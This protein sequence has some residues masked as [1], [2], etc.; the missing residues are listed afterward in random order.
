[1]PQENIPSLLIEGFSFAFDYIKKQV[2]RILS[3]T[4]CWDR[5]AKVKSRT[6]LR[7]TMAYCYLL[8]RIQRS[9]ACISEATMR[10][11]LEAKLGNTPYTAYEIED[12]MKI[13]VPYFYQYPGERHLYQG[14]GK[15]HPYLFLKSGIEALKEQFL[16]WNEE[17]R[18]H[19]IEIL[20]KHLPS[21]PV[22]GE[23]TYYF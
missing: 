9:E 13:N 22:L 15:K 17:Y 8:R 2:P 14:D 18:A 11:I 20:K 1:L 10:N 3:D 6:V 23:L 21:T 16:N 7:E 12:L 4:E 19:A 5:V